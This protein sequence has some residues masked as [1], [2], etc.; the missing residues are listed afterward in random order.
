M[1]KKVFSFFET[2]LFSNFSS[3]RKFLVPSHSGLCW[4]KASIPTE[5]G[6]VRLW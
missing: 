5:V 4:W 6:V 3:F 2:D 1:L